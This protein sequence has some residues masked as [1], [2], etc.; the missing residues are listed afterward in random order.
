MSRGRGDPC[1][2]LLESLFGECCSAA[3]WLLMRG[4]LLEALLSFLSGGGLT[5]GLFDG[6]SLSSGSH[7]DSL[8]SEKSRKLNL[9]VCVC[10]WVGR[11]VGGE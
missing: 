11:R 7:V 4:L 9:C 5:S 3:C 2:G 10:V 1:R 8:Y 6:T